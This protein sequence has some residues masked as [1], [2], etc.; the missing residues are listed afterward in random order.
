[1]H[2]MTPNSW[3]ADIY[4]GLPAP[5]EGEE[6]CVVGAG[7]HI[8]IRF[9]Q[10]KSVFNLMGDDGVAHCTKPIGAFATKGLSVSQLLPAARW[11]QQVEIRAGKHF[12]RPRYEVVRK[13]GR[14]R[15]AHPNVER[16]I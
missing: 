11:P 16:T 10:A 5:D 1:M 4:A 14:R 12:V 2:A 13:N 8:P 7:T 6:V 15:I 9:P 3:P